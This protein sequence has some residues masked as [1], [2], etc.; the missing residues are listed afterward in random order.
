MRRYSSLNWRS[1]VVW[2]MLVGLE[3]G[4]QLALKMAADLT[5]TEMGMVAWLQ[6]LLSSPWFQLSI[7]LDVA[8][9]VAWMAILREHELSFAI[10]V[11]SL[12]YFATILASTLLLREQVHAMQVLGLSAVG[13]GIVLIAAE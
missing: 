11:S 6:A 12:C 3:T 13:F 7:G 2:T 4:A 10:P 8:G 1:Y 9:F 5:P